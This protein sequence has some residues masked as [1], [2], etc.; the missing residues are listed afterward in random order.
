MSGRVGTP[1]VP[2]GMPEARP[3]PST[4]GLYL[5][6]AD[7]SI[8]RAPGFDSNGRWRPARRIAERRLGSVAREARNGPYLA[9]NLGVLGDKVRRPV[10][11]LVAEAWLPDYHPM[12]EVHHVNGDPTDNR[13]QNLRCMTGPEHARLHGRF[14]L[15]AE[16]ADARAELE[17]H[18]GDPPP[19]VEVDAARVA[20]R[21]EAERRYREGRAPGAATRDDEGESDE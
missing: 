8:W 9:V 17:A 13:P 7:G 6:G 10:H 5:A 19:R 3:I 18:R 11:R 14:V 4:G 20:R 21:R 2:A 1:A 16:L 12:L 15:D